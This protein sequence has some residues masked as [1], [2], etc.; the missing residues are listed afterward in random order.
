MSESTQAIFFFIGFLGCLLASF[1]AYWG[2]SPV[3]GW[4]GWH[5]GWFGLAAFIF[6]Y[7]WIAVKAS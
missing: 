5:P 1:S 6:V 2:P 7:F 3:A 4:R